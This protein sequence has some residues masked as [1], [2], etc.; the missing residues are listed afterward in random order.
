MKWQKKGP[1]I[2][3]RDRARFFLLLRKITCK[4]LENKKGRKTNS[5]P[6]RIEMNDF[7]GFSGQGD[8]AKAGF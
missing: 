1:K 5:N 7:L 3:T 8:F 6:L 4:D 2:K